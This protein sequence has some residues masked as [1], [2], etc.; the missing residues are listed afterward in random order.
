MT[1]PSAKGKY[2]SAFI[3]GLEY[4][5]PG[6]GT[7]PGCDTRDPRFKE[8]DAEWRLA[9]FDW[10]KQVAPI[11][12]Q[13]WL[14]TSGADGQREREV[15][16]ELC[17]RDWAYNTT[18]FS[19]TYDPRMRA[20]EATDKAF[21]PFAVQINKIQEFQRVIGAPGK[22]DIFDTKSRGVGWTETYAEGAKSAWQFTDYQI[23][24][25]SYK[26]DKV[27]RRNDRSTIFGKI[28]Y[29]L[30]KTPT[31]L[32][33]ANFVVEDHMLRLNLHNPETGAS[34]TGESTTHRT[35]RGDRKTAII[36]DEAAFVEGG[37]MPVYGVGAGTTD[38]RFCLSTESW[39]EGDDW[40]RL[41]QDE[42]KHGDPARV[43]EVDWWHNAYQ[44]S[45]WYAT[46]KVRWKSDP[47]GF[48]REYERDPEQAA[49]SLMY[50][51]V[52]HCRLTDQ[53]F[54][55]D[56]TLIVSIDPGHADDC[57]ISWGQPIHPEGRKGIRWLGNYKRN[58]APVSFY[59]ILLTGIA[60]RPAHELWEAWCEGE[61]GM[62]G[63]RERQLMAWFKERRTSVS[64][65]QEFIRWCMDPAG[66]QEHAGTS[67]HGL[68]YAATQELLIWEWEDGG[69][70]GSKPKG[71]APNYKFLQE[72]GNLII[73]RVLCTRTYLPASEFSTANPELWRAIDIQDDLRRSAYSKG[74]P[75]SVSQPKPIHGE[76][77]HTRSTVE[78]ASTYLYLGMIDPPKRLARRMLDALQRTA[79]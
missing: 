21:Y 30:D 75:R 38:N 73:D 72:Q 24:F 40:E 25:V 4:A 29:K 19:W 63:P 51:E 42:K 64:H 27:Y 45:A 3:A 23:H 57:A 44:D 55:P 59:A 50:P 28:E 5:Q 58:R 6:L 8:P 46:E 49:S 15:Q 9:W 52:K 12:T 41:W 56:K 14:A 16:H 34:I 43:W 10:R 7:V 35:S 26:E 18:I 39:D 1:E 53:H 13:L 33:P 76:E 77:S 31:W 60:P 68:F 69:N 61:R 62:F 32:M 70:A 11:R 79:A 78:F 2:A 65:M 17:R 74:T 20:G 54:A 67:F 66:K 22:I 47:H 36:Y 37:F 71:I 48:A